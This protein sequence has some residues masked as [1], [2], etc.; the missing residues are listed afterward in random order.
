MD[1]TEW[2][3][4]LRSLVALNEK[5]KLDVEEQNLYIEILKKKIESM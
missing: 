2:E 3:H 4:R 1:K 5:L